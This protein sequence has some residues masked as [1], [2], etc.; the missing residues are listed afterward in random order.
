MAKEGTK[1][2]RLNWL[3]NR[4]V[5]KRKISE[6]TEDIV[7]NSIDIYPETP[8]DEAIPMT[9][10]FR[11]NIYL[12]AL[13]LASIGVFVGAISLVLIAISI[14]VIPCRICNGNSSL[15]SQDVR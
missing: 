2:K 5:T 10:C 14:V 4:N 9:K 7:T 12:P 3:F 1:S 13:G 15:S 6:K 8:N 11:F